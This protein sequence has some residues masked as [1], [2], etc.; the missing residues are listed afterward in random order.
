[1]QKWKLGF[2][3]MALQAKVPIVLASGDYKYK[4]IKI[5]HMISYED[6][7]TRSFESV[8]DEIE[9]YFKDINAK[10]PEN[11]NPKIY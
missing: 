6:L 2:Y 7:T 3:H 8:M 5:G 4:E 11:Y 10:Y 9:N 1:M